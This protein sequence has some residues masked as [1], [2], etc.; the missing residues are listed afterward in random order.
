MATAT[1][2]QPLA[3]GSDDRS[4]ALKR[5]WMEVLAAFRPA[6]LLWNSI[7]GSGGIGGNAG[8]VVASR[9]LDFGK[10]AQFEIFGNVQDPVYVRPGIERTGEQFY[11]GNGTIELDDIMLMDHFI[12]VDQL[13]MSHV[14]WILPAMRH[15]G[16]SL[17]IGFDKRLFITA[18]NAA[19]TAAVT[20]VHDGGTAV[21]RVAASVAAAYPVTST[22]AA[23]ARADID[24]LAKQLSD[25]NVPEMGRRLYVNNDLALALR[26]DTAIFSKDFSSDSNDLN[27]NRMGTISGFEV[28][29]TN[30]L[31]STN[32]A[33]GTSFSPFSFPTKYTGNFTVSGTNGQP[34]AVALC[35]GDQGNAAIGYVTKGSPV[36][37]LIDDTKTVSKYMQAYLHAGAGVLAPYC[38][39]VIQVPSS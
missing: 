39:G 5:A 18:V 32:I 37:N 4:L 20:N 2:V 31:P 3:V 26:Q 35:G 25:K 9:V 19:N 27:A 34:V 16:Q 12:G 11:V 36:V 21:S 1:V 8:Q 28:F 7:D 29:S 6:T 23:N 13:N 22:G 24:T 33:T 17:A 10:S 30:N 38:A 14:D 15:L